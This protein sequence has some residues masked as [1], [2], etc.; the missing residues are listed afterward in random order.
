MKLTE[1][2]ELLTKLEAEQRQLEFS[3]RALTRSV[4]KVHGAIHASLIVSSLGICHT[5]E[6]LIE[7]S[8]VLDQDYI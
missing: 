5:L 6:L 1:Q 7:Q 3:H 4:P 8:V 2:Q